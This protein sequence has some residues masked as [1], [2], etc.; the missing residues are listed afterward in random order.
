MSCAVYLVG[1]IFTLLYLSISC[2]L[3]SDHKPLCG[4]DFPK[5]LSWWLL[6]YLV[7]HQSC[8]RCCRRDTT[9]C[10]GAH[11]KTPCS[12]KHASELSGENHLDQVIERVKTRLYDDCQALVSL[13]ARLILAC[14]RHCRKPCLVKSYD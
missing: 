12:V 14:R 6:R 13:C 1:T 4:Q 9:L 11:I 8:L 2:P 5:L 7:L 3:I 10:L